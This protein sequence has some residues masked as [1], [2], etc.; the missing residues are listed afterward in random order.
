MATNLA[1]VLFARSFISPQCAHT[2]NPNCHAEEYH[3]HTVF[4]KDRIER[5]RKLFEHPLPDEEYANALDPS[6][7]VMA[8]REKDKP[9]H[10]YHVDG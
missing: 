5:L 7:D 9:E 1:A 10:K 8:V 6:C 3:L 4:R 2:R